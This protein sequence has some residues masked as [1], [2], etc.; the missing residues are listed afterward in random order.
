MKTLYLVRGLP[1]AGKSTLAASLGGMHYEADMYFINNEGQYKWDGMQIGEAHAWCQRNAAIAMACG[2]S[3]IVVSNTFTTE[4]ELKPYLDLAKKHNYRTTTIIVENR[5]DTKS[6]H[7]VP[8]EAIEK[9]RERF[10]IKL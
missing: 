1:G 9:M 8:V 6:V 3:K 7:N 4:K 5:N 10:V 2:V